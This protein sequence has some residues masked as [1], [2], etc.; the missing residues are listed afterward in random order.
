MH[1]AQVEEG[2]GSGLPT[3]SVVVPLFNKR[4]HVRRTILRILG[5][6]YPQCEVLVVNDGSTDGSADQIADL[7]DP[8]LRILHQENAGPGAARNLGIAHAQH[9]WIA[10]IDADDSWYP[11]HLRE[12]ARAIL[13][14]PTAGFASTAYRKR[15]VA[16]DLPSRSPEEGKPRLSSY[17]KACKH[18]NVVC[19]STV[20]V[21][22]DVF[23]RVGVFGNFCPGEDTDMWVRIA[24]EEPL[25]FSPRVTAIYTMNTGGIS[26]THADRWRTPKSAGSKPESPVHS[27]L[28]AK[29]RDPDCRQLHAEI[30]AYIDAR[31]ITVARNAI[32]DSNQLCAQQALRRVRGK[33]NRRYLTYRAIAH[34]P[35]PVFA[36]AH[37]T[38]RY[39]QR[40]FR[41]K[42]STIEF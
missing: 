1:K 35:A 22:R 6:D 29:L 11:D 28:N 15:T 5:Q 8:R 3:F 21:R 40:L 37:V 38:W 9:Q 26:E 19:A 4:E 39:A 42:W 13:G 7:A 33:R 25:A 16:A 30:S 32:F 10:F 12:L 34:L 31:A 23:E 24:L 27:L 18:R 2:K 41:R 17:F 20:A 14:F 36:L